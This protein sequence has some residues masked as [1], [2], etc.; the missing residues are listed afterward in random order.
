M[1]SVGVDGLVSRSLVG[2][3]VPVSTVLVARPHQGVE[4]VSICPMFHD[5]S[6]RGN[7][8]V[9]ASTSN[10]PFG[11]AFHS[12]ISVLYWSAFAA[13]AVVGDA[14]MV[15]QFESHG[16]L[17]AMGKDRG[18]IL[19][20][21]LI[22]G[23]AYR[24][25][26]VAL[27]SGQLSG[28]IFIKLVNRSGNDSGMRVASSIVN[29]CIRQQWILYRCAGIGRAIKRSIRQPEGSQWRH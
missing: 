11:R 5:L 14:D 28:E 22:T 7:I 3:N 2:C 19:N 17:V 12:R 15:Q 8:L 21:W 10:F 9:A 29:H 25:N 18:G 6:R 23:P 27:T 20:R 13:T 16:V 26:V 4:K 24:W 1:L